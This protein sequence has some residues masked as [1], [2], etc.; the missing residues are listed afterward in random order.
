MSE[1]ANSGSTVSLDLAP[2]VSHNFLAMILCFTHLG[3]YINYATTY[4]VKNVTSDFVWTGS[5]YINNGPLMVIVPRS[6]FPVTEGD[7]KI[8]LTAPRVKIHGI[9]LLYKTEEA[10]T[11]DEYSSSTVDVGNKRSY[12]FIQH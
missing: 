8:E 7:D 12:D 3:G 1:S 11:T 6:D 5:F 10:T 4:S 2:N 9:H